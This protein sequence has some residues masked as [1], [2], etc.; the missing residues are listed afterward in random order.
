MSI[1][2]LKIRTVNDML[3]GPIS[4][5]EEWLFKGNK[6]GIVLD[7]GWGKG[8]IMRRLFERGWK[9]IGIDPQIGDLRNA[10]M[11]GEPICGVGEMLPLSSNKIDTVISSNV[12]HHMMNYREGILEINRCLKPKGHLLLVE[13]VENNPAIRLA[14]KIYPYYEGMPVRSRFTMEDL[15]SLIIQKNFSIAEEDVG[16]FIAWIFVMLIKRKKNI[17]AIFNLFLPVLEI[18]ELFLMRK[19]KFL[20]KYCHNYFMMVIKN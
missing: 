7:L 14:R 12:L 5:I 2:P 17:A 15:R 19:I 16:G 3:E 6:K 18:L 1:V 13:T 10:R 8:L 9:V 4:L 11:F 20:K